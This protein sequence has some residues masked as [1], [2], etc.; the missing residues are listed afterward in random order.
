[1]RSFS[2][3]YDNR[4]QLGWQLGQNWQLG[5]KLYACS[6]EIVGVPRANGE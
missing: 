5:S 3:T 6:I 4:W 2:K 1:M